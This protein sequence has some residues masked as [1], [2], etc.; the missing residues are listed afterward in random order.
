MQVQIAIDGMCAAGK[1]TMGRILQ[2][3]YSCRLF[4][5]DDF[6]LQP[7]Q[8]T[9]DRLSQIGG[10][11]DYERFKKEILDHLNDREGLEYQI[12]SCKAQRLDCRIQTD[13]TP[14]S[15]IEGS[16][17]QHPFFGDIWDLRFFCEIDPAEQLNRIRIRNGEAMCERFK[18][19][20][21]PKEN[22]YFDTFGIR[23]KSICLT[24]GKTKKTKNSKNILTD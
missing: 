14:L 18:Q 2:S 22:A 24:D 21:I 11:V 13:W 20:W 3:I 23:E 6:F 8:R 15:I 1:S 12:Y 16:Y 4:H 17:S 5:M 9:A 19:E 7:Y 10:N